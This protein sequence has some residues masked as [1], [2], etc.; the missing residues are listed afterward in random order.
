MTRQVAALHLSQKKSIPAEQVK[1]L[2]DEYQYA[3]NRGANEVSRQMHA[4]D[5]VFSVWDGEQLAA[6]CRVL[7]DY[8]YVVSIWDFLVGRRYLGQ[9][10]G[11]LLLKAVQSQPDLFGIKRWVLHS[12]MNREFF[13]QHGFLPSEETL[14]HY[15]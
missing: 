15:G 3:H 14:I 11:G 9:G 4:S 8:S 13:E 10:V 6:Y 12:P 7:T 5:L 2:L 1:R